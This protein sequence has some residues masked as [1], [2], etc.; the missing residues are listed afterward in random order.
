LGH[1]FIAPTEKVAV[2]EKAQLSATDRTLNASGSDGPVTHNGLLGRGARELIGR[3]WRPVTYDLTHP[4]VSAPFWN[5]SGVDRT[6]L[7]SVRSLTTIA[8]G[9]KVLLSS[10]AL[11]S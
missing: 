9:H 4:V 1:V 11:L 2:G 3:S 6:L 8:S 10:V 5:L 7:A